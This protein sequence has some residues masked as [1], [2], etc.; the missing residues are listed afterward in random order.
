MTEKVYRCKVC[1][2][3]FKLILTERELHAGKSPCPGCAETA[4]EEVQEDVTTTIMSRGAECGGQC[5]G[6]P[7]HGRCDGEDVKKD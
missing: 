3:T 4:L 7:S 2:F 5:Q 6:C 1:G